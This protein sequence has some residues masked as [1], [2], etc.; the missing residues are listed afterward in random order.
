[1]QAAGRWLERHVVVGELW[2]AL[3]IRGGREHQEQVLATDLNT[4]SKTTLEIILRDIK[5]RAARELLPQELAEQPG[6]E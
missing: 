3:E 4:R 1:M 5:H 2:L 6:N